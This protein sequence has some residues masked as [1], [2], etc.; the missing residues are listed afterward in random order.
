MFVI[1]HTNATHANGSP[2]C[3]R[4]QLL[5]DL[6]EAFYLDELTQMEV[7]DKFQLARPTVSRLLAEARLKGIIEFKI[8]RAYQSEAALAERLVARFDL[9][10]ADVVS[11]PRRGNPLQSFGRFAA[12]AIHPLLAPRTV[13]GLTLGSAV[14]AT[15]R[16]LGTQ[17]PRPI[18]V[19]QLCGSAGAADPSLDA[20]AIA[21]RL[22]RAFGCEAVHFYAPLV[23]ESRAV[24][25]SLRNNPSNAFC[26]DL[27]RQA[28][29]ALVGVDDFDAFLPC[30]HGAGQVPDIEI[31]RLRQA[32]A[33]GSVGGFSID[34]DGG[35]VE[36]AGSFWLTGI[37]L[38]D[39]LAIGQRIAL[40]IGPEKIRQI[41]GALRGR[42]ITHLVVDKSLALGLLDDAATDAKA[43][44]RDAQ[45]P[46]MIASSDSSKRRISSTVL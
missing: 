6:A 9:E 16:A 1:K 10:R 45:R 5:A 3:E 35:V 13:L 30:I 25:D 33:I 8:H 43:P 18:R 19:V 46:P 2:H 22:A 28:T 12:E 42:L 31:A 17:S 44:A 21:E 14:A 24:R 26:L 36:G 37:E 39:F 15:S 41:R 11:L 23:V 32:G 27:G 40:A 20:H 29:M 34:A 38:A 7:A 4:M